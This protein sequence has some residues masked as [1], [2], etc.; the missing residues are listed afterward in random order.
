MRINKIPAFAE[1]GHIHVLVETHK[2]DRNKYA[3]NPE[4]DIMEVRHTL[5]EGF[6][7][8]FDFGFVPGTKAEDGD[9]MD[10]LLFM[11]APAMSGSLVSSRLIGAIIAKQMEKGS[12]QKI[13]NDR[14]LAIAD[15]CKMY[16]DIK[17]VRELN[18]QVLKQIIRFF[19]FM[20]KILIK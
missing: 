15:T 4:F 7:F 10:V 5:P 6:S 12:N 17:T 11:D 1:N 13:R 18:D 9:P 8:P 16:A 20:K 14:L 3:Y 2:G 19:V